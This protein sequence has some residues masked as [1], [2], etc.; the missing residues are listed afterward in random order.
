[1]EYELIFLAPFP[2]HTGGISYYSTQFLKEAPQNFK[3]IPFGFKRVFPKFLYPGSSLQKF[4]KI[5]SIPLVIDT[6]NP[7]TWKVPN[8]KIKEKGFF[9]I[10]Y[11]TSFLSILYLFIIKKFK[12]NYKNWKVIL[13]CHNVRDHKSFLF[14]EF[15][16]NLTFKEVDGF[17]VHSKKGME[18]LK[19]FQKPILK[20]FLPL[21]PL[22]FDLIEKN[23]ARE[24]L[25]L[26]IDKKIILFLGLIRKYKGI[27]NL[28]ETA[29]LLREED[30]I[31]LIAGD[32]WREG[33]KYL[34]DFESLNFLR[35]F[36]FHSWE[37]ISLFLSSADL[38]FLPYKKAS[39]SGVLMMAYQYNIPFCITSLP[40]LEDYLP[41]N[42]PLLKEPEDFKS[43]ILNFF[44][45][46]EFKESFL[47]KIKEKREEFK[48]E[49][50]FYEFTKFLVEKFL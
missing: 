38:L 5:P 3:I 29:K 13:W 36:G 39:G 22:P 47:K 33:K 16:K 4:E 6:L 21:H 17:I 26:P 35:Y 37:K 12:K 43:F 31:F 42:Y 18:D 11:W 48:W 20:A 15:L 49:R 23:K 41:L 40:E 9:L 30:F 1:M 50:F 34:K 19:N 25:N 7:L 10:P 2:P 27:E 45:K 28:I 46:E 32:L 24:S 8:L 44:E 14:L